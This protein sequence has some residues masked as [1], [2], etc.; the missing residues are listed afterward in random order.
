[1]TERITHT[2]ILEKMFNLRKIQ[3]IQAE[4]GIVKDEVPVLFHHL[5][6]LEDKKE[7]KWKK[8]REIK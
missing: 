4:G 6:V 3:Q 2:V 1:M 7:E 5:N 8:G